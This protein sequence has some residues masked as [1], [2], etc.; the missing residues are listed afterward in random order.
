MKLF[1]IIIISVL[2]SSN[3]VSQNKI[4]G[5]VTNN[6]N[7]AIQATIHVPFLEK[8]TI[9]NLDGIYILENIPNGTYYIVFSSLGHE[10]ISIK[11]TFNDEELIKDIILKES[12]VEIEEII[13]STPFHKLQ[14][15]NV[16]KVERVSTKDLVNSGAMNIS[17]GISLIS[18]VS[19]ISTGTGIGKPVVRGLSSNRVLTY[20]QGVRL[21][22]QQFGDEH[23]LGISGSGIESVEVIK[24]PS[25][26]L[27]GS[28]ALGG[29]LY[30]NP[31][32]F[33]SEGS[34]KSDVESQYFS[35]N[36]GISTNLGFKA[37]GSKFKFLIRG[38]HS[39]Y[40][41][42]KTGSD[43]RVTNSRN[44]EYDLKT[45]F[46]YQNSKIKSTIRY[47][48][49]QSNLGLPEEIG[50]QNTS[51]DLILPYQEIDNHIISFDHILFFSNTSLEFKIGYLHN[52]RRE[53]EEEDDRN[54]YGSSVNDSSLRMKLNT[55]NYDIKYNL[56]EMGKFETIIGVQG[57]FQKNRNHGEELL[58]P[59]ANK[60][61]FGVFFTTH[62]HK[63]NFG[64]QAGLRYDLRKIET[65]PARDPSD[66]NYI[67]AVDKN[68][69]SFNA[70][71]GAKI[72]LKDKFIFRL[73]F[74]SGFR[75]PNLSELASNGIHEGTNRYEIGNSEL[76]NEQNYQLDLSIEYNDEHLN[77]FVNGFYNVLSEYIFIS[78]T[79][80]LIEDQPVYSYLQS[81]AN[82]YGGEIGVHIHPHPLD[83]FHIDSSYEMVVGELKN[84]SYLPLIPAHNLRNT[85][86][87]TLKDGKWCKEPVVF[88]T[89]HNTF[90]QN[91][92]SEFETLTKG[93]D[94]L[95]L[96]AG[97]KLNI[98]SITLQINGNITNLTN[99]EYIPHLSRLKSDGIG[100]IGRSYNLSLK[101]EL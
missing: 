100:N 74:A 17:N 97:M 67:D 85:F 55:L 51:R 79:G 24:G 29:V 25:S 82:L 48:Y 87:F 94:L 90:S 46:R 78:P 12:A 81:D 38:S 9:T 77:L 31:E 39:S 11:I 54:P 62:Y 23:G 86:R 56:P 20:T 28:D 1:K 72:D 4:T 47:N 42:Y 96:G 10:T 61:D 83:W 63:E 50:I 64:L 71:L 26:L 91:S 14:S 6:Q 76:N 52:D 18:G 37:S 16:M 66:F 65:H 70:A 40:S 7:L 57:M 53:Y 95:S 99:E 68:F 41:D 45:G 59:D 21:E 75:A 19:I 36:H 80:D 33:A 15:E 49:N 3:A 27:Y 58:I 92:I 101:L 69:N 88:I 44:N 35:N 60:K 32:R 93:Y 43:L 30:F 2:L 98:Q 22:N 5:N 89:Y 8:G 84:G 13:I 34:I 73:N